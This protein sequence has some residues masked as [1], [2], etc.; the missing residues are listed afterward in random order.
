MTG[1]SERTANRLTRERRHAI[2]AEA[3]RI[4]LKSLIH[5]CADLQS[6]AL[7]ERLKQGY[8][9]NVR[10]QVRMWMM[11]RLRKRTKNIRDDIDWQ[12]PAMIHL[13]FAPDWSIQPKLEL[14]QY[15]DLRLPK[16]V[17]LR[18]EPEQNLQNDG[19]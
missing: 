18:R 10:P 5:R 17:R 7:L 13:V 14:Q 16:M 15:L 11:E 8:F 9:A 3:G 6:R 2:V 12:E 19:R 4:D 1:V